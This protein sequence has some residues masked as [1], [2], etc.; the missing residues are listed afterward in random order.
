MSSEDQALAQ[1]VRDYLFSS[2]NGNRAGEF[3]IGTLTSLKQLVGN[4]LQDEKMPGLHV[5][6]GNPYPQFTGADW[7]ASI[8]VDVIPA[9]CTIEVDGRII[10][11]DGVFTL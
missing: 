9:N 4:L 6:F 2:P 8:H 7:D 5:A 11:R 1:E 3:A 10:M